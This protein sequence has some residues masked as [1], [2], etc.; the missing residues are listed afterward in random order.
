MTITPF[1]TLNIALA[2]RASGLIAAALLGLTAIA[3]SA[4]ALAPGEA[5]VTVTIPVSGIG[6]VAQAVAVDPDG[7]IVLAGTNGGNSSVLV[8]VTPSGALDLSFG[9]LGIAINDLSVN[10]G[11]ALRALVRLDDGHYLGCGS[12]S[13]IATGSDFVV[14][15]F[16]S[17]GALDPSFAGVGYAVTAFVDAGQT[18]VDQCNALA[19]QAD[20]MV[21]AA[22]VTTSGHPHVALARYTTSG[23][24]DTNFGTG[25]Q[26]DINAAA[27]AS[28]DSEA[29]AVQLQP[30]GKIL[31]G[32]YAFGPGNSELLVMRLN[33]NG[34]LDSGFGTG[35]ITRTPV[36]TSED[37]A[38]ALVRQP[39]GRIVLAGSE[40][41][42]DGR[43]DF[44]LARYTTAG[45][46]DPTFGTGG[47]VTT[48]VGPSDDIAFALTLMPWGRLVAGGSAR[49]NTST[50]ETDLAV[51][52]YNADG[53]LDRYFGVG[54]KRTVDVSSLQNVIY[55]LATDIGGAHFWAGGTAAPNGV[56][57]DFL[58]VEFGLPD[59]IF[60]HGFETA[61]AP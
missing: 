7:N 1:A 35:G 39:D 37:I 58:V 59:T 33:S 17:N 45:V 14:A 23:A 50:A 46:L 57:Q 18:A 12:F 27:T 55:G 22:G 8:R 28:G 29:R 26:V 44:A 51:V 11:D 54:G 41:A 13:S 31:I 3:P 56:D 6:D 49:I 38:N 10:R 34:S 19:V 16:N 2:P 48:P 30:D 4:S 40:I 25:G 43:R 61:T 20:G 53:S 36:G 60:R 15:R 9:N 32:G 21:V 47:L 5:G 24:L 42:A 52:A